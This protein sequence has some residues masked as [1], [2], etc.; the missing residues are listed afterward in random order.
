MEKQKN[1][2]TLQPHA[3]KESDDVFVS[4]KTDRV[5]RDFAKLV[6]QFEGKKFQ[7]YLEN[8]LL[9]DFEQKKDLFEAYKSRHAI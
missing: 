7:D 1:T 6:A 4:F 8:L 5:N 9:Q 2:I 3:Q